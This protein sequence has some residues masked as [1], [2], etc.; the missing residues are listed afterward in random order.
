M[1]KKKT[2]KK[3]PGKR[4]PI[5]RLTESKKAAFLLAFGKLGNI[6]GAADAANICPKTHYNW[7]DSDPDYQAKFKEAFD[8]ACAETEAEIRRRAIDGWDEPV[9]HKGEMVGTVRKYSDTLLI[10]RA[11]RLM[12][13]LYRE[14]HKVDLS[15]DLNVNNAKQLTDEQLEAIAARCLTGA[16]GGGSAGAPSGETTRQR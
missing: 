4:R 8:R 10:F 15:G 12:P 11:K 1:A 6:T 9:W 7:L 13:D 3:T 16:S 14:N 5:T 2:A